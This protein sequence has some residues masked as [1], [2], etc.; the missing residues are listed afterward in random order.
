MLHRQ[1]VVIGAG[2]GGYV[3]AIKAAQLGL[4]VCVVERAEA[5]G[6]CLN[7]GC[8]PTKT[9]LHS[10]AL[11]AELQDAAH[12][13]IIVDKANV[14]YPA[15]RAR[16]R[17]VTTQLRS[18][19]EGLFTANGVELIRG[20][21]H[22]DSEGRVVIHNTE[23]ADGETI[24][25]ADDI[26]IATGSSP[27]LPPIEGINQEGVLTSDDLLA[28][29][30]ELK[31]L[32]IIGGG[33]IGVEFACA[34]AALGTQVEIFEMASR[35]L[36]TMDKDI[37]T[38]CGSALKKRGINIRT[39]AAVKRIVHTTAH[40]LTVEAVVKNKDV[41]FEADAVLVATGRTSNLDGLFSESYTPAIERGRIVVDELGRT[42]I[43]HLWAIGDVAGVA[44]QLA[45]A[46]SAQGIIAVS[47]IAQKPC[48]IKANVIPSCVYSFPEVASVGMSEEE[49][50]EAGIEVRV[51]KFP[52]GG[53]GKTLIAERDRG[54]IKILAD[55][56]DCVVGA[57]LVCGHATDIIGELSCAMANG[58][59]VEELASAIRPHPTFEEGVGEAV[60]ALLDGAIHALPIKR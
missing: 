26:I 20:N 17:E 18:G 31:R 13:G 11:F 12:L 1:L 30:P 21:A 44:P 32:A 5:G 59:T 45:H 36:P 27:A 35:I 56:N 53:N 6:V 10:A 28:H 34:Y 51:G 29:I 33:V 52:M 40:T 24:I 41:T 54:F 43:E 37:G 14:D 42:N 48:S 55:T 19:V 49:A 46:A 58:L 9:I 23:T 57:H 25:E 50:Q 22:L 60:E 2:P 39:G 4:E 38:T 3:A 47:S 8:I 7:R 15:L 16:T